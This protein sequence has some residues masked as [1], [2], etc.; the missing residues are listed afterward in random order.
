MGFGFKVAPRVR[1]YPSS[2]GHQKLAASPVWLREHVER[3]A[4]GTSATT[5]WR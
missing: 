4:A 1:V 2:R 5:P 3:W